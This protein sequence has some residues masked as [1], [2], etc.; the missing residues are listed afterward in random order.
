M[1]TCNK[2]VIKTLKTAKKTYTEISFLLDSERFENQ[3][4]DA[5]ILRKML[6]DIH[7]SLLPI[8]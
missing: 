5:D 4:A 8:K 6:F 1:K 7:F 2:P 3:T